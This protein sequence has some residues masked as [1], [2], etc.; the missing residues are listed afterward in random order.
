MAEFKEKLE[1]IKQRHHDELLTLTRSGVQHD[2]TLGTHLDY[3]MRRCVANKINPYSTDFLGADSCIHSDHCF[4]SELYGE[5]WNEYH[6]KIVL[7]RSNTT[8]RM[9]RTIDHEITHLKEAHSAQRNALLD[10]LPVSSFNDPWK[11]QHFKQWIR[12]CEKLA[13]LLPIVRNQCSLQYL[14][15]YYCNEYPKDK[16][17]RLKHHEP[18]LEG[19]WIEDL[20]NKNVAELHQMP[21]N[22]SPEDAIHPSRFEILPWIFK[23]QELWDKKQKS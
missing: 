20:T 17:D 3:A 11:N 8:E 14:I 5:E 21:W 12:T 22:Q 15:N 6:P 23:I 18:C 9:V 13:E 7:C 2:Q 1:K 10:L 16:I 19:K 4:S